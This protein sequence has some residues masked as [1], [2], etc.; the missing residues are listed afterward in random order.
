MK[1]TPLT[2]SF[3]VSAWVMAKGHGDERICWKGR[4]GPILPG[5]GYNDQGPRICL[6]CVCFFAIEILSYGK[7]IK[8]N[9][10]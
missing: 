6:L 5:S 8:D 3:S 10:L 7:K 9:D 1:W 4:G 2:S